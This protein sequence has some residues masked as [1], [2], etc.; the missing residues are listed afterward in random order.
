MDLVKEISNDFSNL[1]SSN[2]RKIESLPD[3]YPAITLKSLNFY[4]VGIEYTETD[5]VFESFANVRMRTAELTYNGE[6]KRFLL[7]TSSVNELRNEFAIICGNFLEPG[8]LGEKRKELLKDPVSWWENWSNLLGNAVKNKEVYS[9]FG[10]LLA[11]ESLWPGEGNIRE[12]WAGPWNGTHD[13]ELPGASYEI[14]STIKKFDSEIVV[15]SQYQFER[16]NTPLYLFFY[17]FE[18]SMTGETIDTL[19]ERMKEKEI[20]LTVI[21]EVLTA[22]GLEKG[23][24][25]RKNKYKILEKRIYE[26]DENFPLISA[27]SFKENALPYNVKKFSYTIDLE[28]LEY[29]KE[30]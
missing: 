16:N 6:E 12:I 5:E 11:L 25:K 4:G 8:Y 29:T 2:I 18:K 14:K 27:K 22:Y 1:T 9:L 3:D 7:L 19:L 21:E 10:E 30:I 20:D 15:S 28:G 13:I 23:N 24:S 17:R 26:I